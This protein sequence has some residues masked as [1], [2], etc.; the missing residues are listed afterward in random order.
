MVKNDNPF[1]LCHEYHVNVHTHLNSTTSTTCHR[2]SVYSSGKRALSIELGMST[3]MSTYFQPTLT[4]ITCE[5]RVET[6]CH[7]TRCGSK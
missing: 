6:D 4:I 3:S 7:V 2:I 5:S 1:I